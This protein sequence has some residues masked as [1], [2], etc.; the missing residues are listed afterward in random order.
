MVKTLDLQ[1]LGG[2]SISSISA[3][4]CYATPSAL[5]QAFRRWEGTSP[6]VQFAKRGDDG[7]MATQ[8]EIDLLRDCGVE[9]LRPILPFRTLEGRHSPEPPP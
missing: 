8:I 2:L 9:D 1:G 7:A 6:G 5:V 3:T 4:L